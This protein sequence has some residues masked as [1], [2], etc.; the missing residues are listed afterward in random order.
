ML[1]SGWS[2]LLAWYGTALV[3]DGAQLMG[4]VTLSTELRHWWWFQW[5][6]P[7]SIAC[8]IHALLCW[9][10]VI[11]GGLAIG[12][13]YCTPARRARGYHWW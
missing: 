9:W 6:V 3:A 12:H 1:G 4:G 10:Q 8:W 11:F 13:K 2:L 5:A 7:Y